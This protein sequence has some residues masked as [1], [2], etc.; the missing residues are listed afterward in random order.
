MSEADETIEIR[1]NPGPQEEFLST[2][3]DI[4][5]YGGAAGGGKT[6][7]VLLDGLRWHEDPEFGGVVF[8]REGVDLTG[9][10]SVWEEATKLYSMFGCEFRQAP[11]LE[12]RFPSGASIIFRHLQ[13]ESDRLSHQ[14]KQYSWI[15]FE[16]L[17]HFVESQFWYLWG[18]RR[19]RARVR[20]Y[21]RATCN[22]DPDSFVRKMIDWWIGKDGY[23]IPE[24][25]GVIRY[26]ARG[27]DDELVWADTREELE[28]RFR[29]P[30]RV[31][32]FTFILSRL[33][34]NPKIDPTYRAALLSLDRVERERL[35][36]DE[37][38]GGNWNIRPAAGLYFKRSMFDVREHRPL[39][40]E[41]RRRV[42][43]WDKAA[44][45]E[46]GKNDPDW[47]VGVLL[48]ELR[49]GG[50]VIEHAEFVR[51]R[52]AE[53]EAIMRT[54]AEHDGIGVDVAV[55][56]D[57][58]QAGV[59]DVDRMRVVLAGFRVAVMRASSDK[60]TYAGTWQSQAEGRRVAVVRGPW[61]ERLFSQLESFP[62]SRSHDD[63]V[64]AAS[65][66]FQV[67]FGTQPTEYGYQPAKKTESDERAPR[68]PTHGI[69]GR[70]ML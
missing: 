2:S 48:A 10:G 55:W 59:V 12:A 17:T 6:F 7:S 63:A 52:P 45:V 57:P 18:R 24:R 68:L 47:T 38:R 49:N 66:A 43:A 20:P 8:R 11:Y 37:E 28:E 51:G 31:T 21:L 15:A 50:Y 36:G 9:P 22:P 4:A 16:E 35:L 23:A 56:Q 69:R 39:D 13:H 42:R 53:V 41:V 70:G 19:T 60:L 1:P 34:D 65:L 62:S 64:D 29:D 44:T 54:I 5:F 58:G 27:D 46:T 25:S 30:E 26:F 33:K 3:A 61:N 40:S 67:L 32:S 14:G